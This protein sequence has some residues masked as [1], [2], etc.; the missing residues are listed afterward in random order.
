MKTRTTLMLC[1]LAVLAL[2]WA[3]PAQAALVGYWNLNEGSGTTAKDFLKG[4]NNDGTLSGGV[5]WVT[6][7]TGASGDY[8]VRI[9]GGSDYIT[10]PDSASFDTIT[11]NFTIAAWVRELGGTNYGHVFV[12][13]TN[14]AARNWLLQTS[15]WGGDSM[16]VWSDTNGAWNKSLGYIL[17]G[18]N[19]WHHLALTYDGTNMRLY[20]DGSLAGTYGVSS[21]FPNFGGALYIGGWLAGGSSFDGDIDDAV[22]FNSVENVGQIMAGTHPDMVPEPATLALL[23]LGGLSLLLRRKRR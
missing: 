13:T 8:A 6:G 10:V 16:Y 21:T 17:P 9:P 4:N 14:Y 19:G 12:T 7:H 3:T 23:G 11:N 1:V 15:A 20:A 5:S 18:G 2:A 22:V